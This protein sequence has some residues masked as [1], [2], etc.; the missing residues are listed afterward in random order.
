M[1]NKYFESNC[2]CNCNAK[3]SVTSA[4]RA[5]KYSNISRNRKEI[6]LF[7]WFQTKADLGLSRREEVTLDI[8]LI[9]HQLLEL[10]SCQ[11]VVQPNKMLNMARY[12]AVPVRKKYEQMSAQTAQ[13][14]RSK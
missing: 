13:A 12:A 11:T 2:N 14:A 6:A 10:D 3:K 8:F 1:H 9:D 5:F 7:G 4:L